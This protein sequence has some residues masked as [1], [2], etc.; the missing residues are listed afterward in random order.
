MTSLNT[1]IITQLDLLHRHKYWLGNIEQ[2]AERWTLGA[3]IHFLNRY[4]GN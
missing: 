3:L 1:L 2:L 4:V